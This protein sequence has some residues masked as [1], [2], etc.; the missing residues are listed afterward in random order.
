MYI[1]IYLSTF[2]SIHISLSLVIYIYICIYT[3][4][5]ML[6]KRVQFVQMVLYAYSKSAAETDR[7]CCPSCAGTRTHGCA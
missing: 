5:N 1:S 7:A 3:Y 2:V 6:T 4:I